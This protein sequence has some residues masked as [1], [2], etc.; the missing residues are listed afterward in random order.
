MYTDITNNSITLTW[1][2]PSLLIPTGYK[3]ECSCQ[4]TFD[5]IDV[6]SFITSPPF[7]SSGIPPDGHCTFNLFGLYGNDTQYL[8][9]GMSI[10]K[11]IVCSLYYVHI[12]ERVNCNIYGSTLTAPSCNCSEI[13]NLNNTKQPS[14]CPDSATSPIIITSV[15]LV[16]SI[17]I[18]IIPLTIFAVFCYKKKVLS[19]RYC[20]IMSQVINYI[21]S[22]NTKESEIYVA[23]S[24]I[25]AAANMAYEK[26]LPINM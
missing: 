12:L 2:P 26:T 11:V 14:T 21:F 19:L 24:G 4:S 23:N 8:A 1:S 16:I 5:S 20:N 7:L 17:L 3:I 9:T 22:K 25:K 15:L 10:V 13:D 6:I 18:N